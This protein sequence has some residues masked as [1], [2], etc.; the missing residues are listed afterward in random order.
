MSKASKQA[1]PDMNVI[2]TA[3]VKRYWDAKE[4]SK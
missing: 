1:V 4:A 2:I 3:M